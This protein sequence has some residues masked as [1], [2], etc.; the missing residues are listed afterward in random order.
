MEQKKYEN[1]ADEKLK[2]LVERIERLEEEKSE[3]LKQ[4]SEIY[5]DA[6]AEGF[7]TKIIKK[8]IK[9]RK[10]DKAELQEEAYLMQCYAEAI[11]MELF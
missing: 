2:S 7:D 5:K 8:L 10:Q 1:K 9:I 11:Q 4:I 6:K 3:V